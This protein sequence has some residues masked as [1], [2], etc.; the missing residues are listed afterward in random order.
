[1]NA[2]LIKMSAALENQNS[3]INEKDA[4]ISKK[5]KKIKYFKDLLK[6][7]VLLLQARLDRVLKFD[8]VLINLQHLRLIEMQ[9]AGKVAPQTHSFPST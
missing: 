2:A 4:L 8:P 9:P 1:M 3:V 5:E 7:N 6:H